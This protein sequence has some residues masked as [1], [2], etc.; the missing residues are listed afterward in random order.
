M[1]L[2]DDDNAKVTSGPLKD[3]DGRLIGDYVDAKMKS[4]KVDQYLKERKDEKSVL[5]MANSLKDSCE[6]LLETYPNHKEVKAWH[7]KA[8]GLIQKIAA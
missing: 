6:R 4:E 2:Y 7:K 1:G 5:L 3:S 8:E